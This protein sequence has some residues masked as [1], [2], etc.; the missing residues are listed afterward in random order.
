MID[1]FYQKVASDKFRPHF[2]KGRFGR[3]RIKGTERGYSVCRRRA[4]IRREPRSATYVVP[5]WRTRHDA[6]LESC[7]CPSEWKWR[8]EYRWT[9]FIWTRSADPGFWH[10]LKYSRAPVI[11]SHSSVRGICNHSRNLTDEVNSSVNRQ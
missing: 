4:C 6:D 8:F 9:Y 3:M 5:P 10:V 7:Q 11:A 1:I 2:H